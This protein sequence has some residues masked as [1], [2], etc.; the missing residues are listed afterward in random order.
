MQAGG[1]WCFDSSTRNRFKNPLV[2]ILEK[3]FCEAT[4]EE[5]LSEISKKNEANRT[6]TLLFL[7]KLKIF[8]FTAY[9]NDREKATMTNQNSFFFI[10]LK[11]HLVYG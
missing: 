8:N 9:Y 6:K 11:F 7:T 3:G 1:N 2:L 5:I 10:F 4:I